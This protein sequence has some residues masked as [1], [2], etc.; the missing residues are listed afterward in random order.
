LRSSSVANGSVSSNRSTL[1]ACAIYSFLE[2][3][4]VDHPAF[5]RLCPDVV[6]FA[7][8]GTQQGDLQRSLEVINRTSRRLHDALGVGHLT[9][10]P[11]HLTLEH[12]QRERRRVVGREQLLA[13]VMQASGALTS[14][15]G[16]AVGL[17][18]VG[19]QLA[20]EQ[21]G[22]AHRRQHSGK[23]QLVLSSR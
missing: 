20:H 2:R 3:P 13:F 9:G 7:L 8:A 4:L 15:F 18:P 10:Q 6:L 22:A 23:T 16:V 11:I 14:P 17:R 1:P 19:S 5:S 12:V 21:P